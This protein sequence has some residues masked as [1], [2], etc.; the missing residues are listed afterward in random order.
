MTADQA[1]IE[2]KPTTLCF[3]TVTFTRWASK[4]MM[5]MVLS[6]SQ[7]VL[8][9]A[10]VMGNFT[11]LQVWL[12]ML[13]A[14]HKHTYT[15]SSKVLY[16]RVT[17]LQCPNNLK[18]SSSWW[19]PCLSRKLSPPHPPRIQQHWVH[20]TLEVNPSIVLKISF[21]ENNIDHNFVLNLNT[22]NIQNKKSK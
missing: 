17:F 10:S 11:S 2:K 6:E 14:S 9:K 12:L 8:V 20:F 1:A 5:V 13:T 15:S 22:Q 19:T 18:Y 3:V 16:P 21:D 4:W 7:W